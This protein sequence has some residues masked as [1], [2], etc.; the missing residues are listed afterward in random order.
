MKNK[1]V[2]IKGSWKVFFNGYMT[3]PDFNSKGAALTYMSLLEKSL[4]KPEFSKS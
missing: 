2:N 3:S 1:V 4:R